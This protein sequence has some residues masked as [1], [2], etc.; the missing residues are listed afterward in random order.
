MPVVVVEV[1]TEAPSPAMARALVDACSASVREGTCELASEAAHEP[2]LA[3]VDVEFVDASER[4]AHVEVHDVRG[5]VPG[6]HVRILTFKSTDARIERWRAVGLTIATLVGDALPAPTTLDTEA[7]FDDATDANAGAAA[8]GAASQ[9]TQTP[10]LVAVAGK[11]ATTVADETPAP[12]A[13][14]DAAPSRERRT[15]GTEQPL[16][17]RFWAGLSLLTGS[18]LEAGAP[19]FGVGADASYRF[20]TLPFFARLSVGYASRG[21]DSRGVSVQWES[22]TLGAGAVVGSDALRLE[23]RIAVGIEN[24]HAGVVDPVTRRS[25]SGNRFGASAHFG[26]DGV[27]QLGRFGLVAT[28]E[29]AEAHSPTRIVV[30]DSAAGSVA[31]TSWAIGL[32]ARYFV[33]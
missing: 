6:R 24:L 29:V 3:V 27:W 13:N 11:N 12:P 14:A 32:G 5:G 31:A 8:P 20:A 7:R 4:A 23:P 9:T 10:P 25:D 17:R 1:V 16:P 2:H 18:G 26:L 15:P 22:A 33:R 30:E 19:R 21:E 28:V